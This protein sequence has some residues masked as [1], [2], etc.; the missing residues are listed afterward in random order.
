MC[1]RV[2]Q[3]YA[4]ATAY[5]CAEMASTDKK[6]ATVT[7]SRQIGTKRHKFCK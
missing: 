4:A 6:C 5:T 1:G 7:K 3:M 2:A